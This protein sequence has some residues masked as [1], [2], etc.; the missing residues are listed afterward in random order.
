MAKL[1]TVLCMLRMEITSNQTLGNIYS[2]LISKF[3]LKT[4]VS[5]CEPFTTFWMDTFKEG[6][7]MW[8]GNSSC[9]VRC[10]LTKS[11][12]DDCSTKWNRSSHKLTCE[13]IPNSAEDR[14]LSYSAFPKWYLLWLRKD[15]LF[16]FYTVTD[17][18]VLVHKMSPGQERFIHSPRT[19]SRCFEN[20]TPKAKT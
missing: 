9:T 15:Q 13:E 18:S 1:T 19:G 4:T 12:V 14:Q 3:G 20:I 10:L 5:V 17:A 2:H 7:E 11:F 6:V 8:S 16:L